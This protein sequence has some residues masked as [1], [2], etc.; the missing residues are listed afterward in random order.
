MVLTK[1]SVQESTHTVRQLL[2]CNH[3]CQNYSQISEK[4]ALQMLS[5][6]LSDL[7]EPDDVNC[8]LFTRQAQG[9]PVNHHKHGACVPRRI[10]SPEAV[11]HFDVLCSQ[12]LASAPLPG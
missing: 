4:S 12:I 7:K 10:W 1:I 11:A 2:T 9:A 6:C 3:K 5:T 8:N